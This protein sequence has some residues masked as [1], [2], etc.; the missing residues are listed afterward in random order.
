MEDSL[1]KQAQKRIPIANKKRQWVTIRLRE[2]TRGIS[3]PEAARIYASFAF[4][5]TKIL[6]ES[7]KK[8]TFGHPLG[9]QPSHNQTIQ[10]V[11]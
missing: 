9:C 2:P 6:V 10:G 7:A 5:S 11:R 1:G 3:E 4:K 8:M